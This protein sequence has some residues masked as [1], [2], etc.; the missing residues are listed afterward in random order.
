ME[1]NNATTADSTEIDVEKG[2]IK[3]E[4]DKKKEKFE[5]ASDSLELNTE[6]STSLSLAADSLGNIKDESNGEGVDSTLL[7]QQ[8]AELEQE[9]Q[10]MQDLKDAQLAEKSGKSKEK[11]LK[12]KV[13]DCVYPN[14]VYY[15]RNK[16]TFTYE[17]NFFMYYIHQKYF[18]KRTL[19]DKKDSTRI[20][21]YK[22]LDLVGNSMYRRTNFNKVIDSISVLLPDYDVEAFADSMITQ[23]NLEYLNTGEIKVKYKNKKQNK[24]YAKVQPRKGRDLGHIKFYTRNKRT[25]IEQLNGEDYEGLLPPE[26]STQMKSLADS[27]A[28][29]KAKMTADS[30]RRDSIYRNRKNKVK[31]DTIIEPIAISNTSVDS[32]SSIMPKKDA[33]PMI[34]SGGT[35]AAADSVPALVL[36]GVTTP[37][38][39]NATTTTTPTTSTETQT[40]PAGGTG[41]DETNTD[42]KKKKKDKKKKKKEQQEEE[43]KNGEE[44]PTPDKVENTA[45]ADSLPTTTPT[46]GDTVPADSTGK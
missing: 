8:I 19:Y 38:A 34:N 31:G 24:L 41:T 44:T 14:T 43:Q 22:M 5:N 39:P 1:G 20:I 33:A 10:N 30:V 23:C 27:I 12:I 28:A 7:A 42:K 18:Y 9:M 6:D 11:V 32:L 29:V 45:P 3:S 4:K 13:P 26:D 2:K 15:T 25:V 36:P 37:A 46:P 35:K 17:Y 40:E 16:F 21:A